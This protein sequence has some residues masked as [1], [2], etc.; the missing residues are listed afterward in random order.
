MECMA[1]ATRA[2]LFAN[3]PVIALPIT[4]KILVISEMGIELFFSFAICSSLA[5]NDLFSLTAIE[6]K[7]KL[8]SKPSRIRYS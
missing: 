4:S 1:S 6:L 8:T 5:N 2:L 7:G 3:K